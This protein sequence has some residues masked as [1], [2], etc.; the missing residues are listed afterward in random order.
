MAGDHMGTLG[1]VVLG[2]VVV[3]VDLTR[4]KVLFTR[5]TDNVRDVCRA[6]NGGRQCGQTLQQGLSQ[7]L[8]AIT[9]PPITHTRRRNVMIPMEIS[10]AIASPQEIATYSRRM[11]RLPPR[12]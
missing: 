4:V 1:R 9:F 12:P 6:G 8:T 10:A 3:I 7:C 5:R 11:V 2:C